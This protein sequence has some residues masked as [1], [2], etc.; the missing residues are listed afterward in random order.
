MEHALRQERIIKARAIL[1]NS[2]FKRKKPEDRKRIVKTMLERGLRLDDLQMLKDE[3]D[4]QKRFNLLDKG[5]LTMI[6]LNLH[7]R[8][9]LATC[10]TQRQYAAV[11]QD[12]Q[13]FKRLLTEHYPGAF[14]TNDPH[15]QYVAITNGIQTTYLFPWI[16]DGSEYERPV[17]IG[18]SG[19]P[20]DIPGWS[21]YGVDTSSYNNLIGNELFLASIPA[22]DAQRFRAVR[23]LIDTKYQA[24]FPG[25]ARD[26]I[27]HIILLDLV[28]S[29]FKNFMKDY[30]KLGL[31]GILEKVKNKMEERIKLY[32]GEYQFFTSDAVDRFEKHIEFL[33][34][35]G[36]PVE[37]LTTE[38][39]R[40]CDLK[41]MAIPKETTG[42]IIMENFRDRILTIKT[43]KEYLASYLLEDGFDTFS[44]I[45]YRDF[46][47]YLRFD[48]SFLDEQEK[49]LPRYERMETV[50]FLRWLKE[51]S[52]TGLTD[53]NEKSLRD[54][55]MVHDKLTVKPRNMGFVFRQ[56]IF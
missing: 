15:K 2:D 6:L 55:V 47:E 45:L 38:S 46:I 33:S 56:V 41:G 8:D 28:E 32:P 37:Y 27:V 52:G 39:G 13:I 16:R 20:E 9:V 50:S 54:Y 23:H 24:G 7:P 51:K 48:P 14:F 4:Q 43:K 3:L 17:Q 21:L 40:L 53:L 30:R 12:P 29:H 1:N 26:Q 25:L 18:K 19:R 35:R 31:G 42:W 36:R 10:R 34:L 44:W 5:A 49:D 22:E 11:C